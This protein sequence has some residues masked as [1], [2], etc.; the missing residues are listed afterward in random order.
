SVTPA[1]RP[2]GE[3]AAD[4][5]KDLSRS[6]RN[7]KID[8]VYIDR[9]YVSSELVRDASGAGAQVFCKP[10]IAPNGELFSK[11]AFKKNFKLRTI[12]CPA[13]QTRRFVHGQTVEFD[14]EICGACS[15][16]SRCTTASNDA[17]RTVH[18]A[19]DEQ[20]QQ[21]F[22]K[23]VKTT[24]GRE[25]LRQR[26]RVEHRLA[27]LSRKQGPRA[28]YLGLRKNLFDLRRHCAVLN[29]EVILRRGGALALHKAA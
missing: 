22:R 4:L 9:A 13:G 20:E 5:A 12:T 26:V 8:E 11:D 25:A 23:L 18:I 27:H 10:R 7:D 6:P 29:L 2:E 1:N 28:R 14:P 17:G 19:A 15:L 24:K 16:R 3:G 21:R